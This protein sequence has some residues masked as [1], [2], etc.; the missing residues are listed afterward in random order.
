LRQRSFFVPLS[1]DSPRF[2]LRTRDLSS[3]DAALAATGHVVVEGLWDT[4]YLAEVRTAADER[5]RRDDDRFALGFDGFPDSVVECYLGSF[6][7]LENLSETDAAA[8]AEADRRFFAAAELSGLPG[9][10][11]VLLNGDF[12]I[13]R[14]ERVIRRADPRFTIRFIGLHP[15]G[16]LNVCSGHAFNTKRELTIW[17][18]LQDCTTDD[19]PR[20]LLMH[21]GETYTDLF[22]ED[23][24]PAIERRRKQIRNEAE[25][26]DVLKSK[27]DAQY[28]LL[29]RHRRCFAPYVPFGGSIIFEAGVFHA[30]YVREGMTAS[31][32]SLDFRSVG[33]FRRTTANRNYVGRTFRAA[34]VEIEA[35]AGEILLARAKRAIKRVSRRI[36]A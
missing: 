30:S 29:F 24:V 16:Q 7:G 32:F 13:G 33:D 36:R 11:R 9:L 17:T 26:A 4:E 5:F 2:S 20:L 31:R 14:S 6:V 18:P 3:I 28:E 21:K 27:T 23:E 34:P 19:T 25:V 10:L 22:A 15:D 8:N 12:F 1:F 35:P